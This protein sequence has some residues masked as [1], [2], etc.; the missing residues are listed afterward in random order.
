MVDMAQFGL[1]VYDNFNGGYM[2]TFLSS[3]VSSVLTITFDGLAS[4][5]G[6]SVT[7][8]LV[9]DIILNGSVE[10]LSEWPNFEALF[11]PVVSV[12]NE[13]QQLSGDLTGVSFTVYLIRPVL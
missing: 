12:N 8:L 3:V 1:D 6:V 4:S 13:L 5:G 9:G 10:G 7:G 11:E 2:S